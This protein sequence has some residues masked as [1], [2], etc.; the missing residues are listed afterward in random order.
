MAG[1]PL[2]QFWGFAFLGETSQIQIE[3]NQQFAAVLWLIYPTECVARSHS[4]WRI[5]QITINAAQVA[6]RQARGRLNFDAAFSVVSRIGSF[7]L[8]GTYTF[9]VPYNGME[10]CNMHVTCATESSSRR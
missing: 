3:S 4:S 6:K 10:T 9:I 1:A 2:L 8:T 5:W 7:N